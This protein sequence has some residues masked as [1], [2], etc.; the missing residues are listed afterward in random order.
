MLK[1]KD[2]TL[3][4]GGSQILYDVSLTAAAGE[5]TCIMGTNGVGKT[6]LLKA[7]S[8]THQ[9]TSGEIEFD[10]EAIGKLPAH[11]L[12]QKGIGYVPQGRMIFPLL[13]VKENMET[14]YAC[15]P[16]SEHYVPDEIY[17]L[18]PILKEFLNRRGGD[19]SGGQQQQLA[20][21]RAMLT[22]PKL[23]LLDEPT[24]GIQPNIIQQIGRVIRYL[25]DKGDIA[26]ILVEQYFDFA[27]EN[28]DRF[29]V[30][31][32]GA[33]MKSGSHDDLSRAELLEATSV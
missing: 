23:L 6:S 11:A 2:L 8:G 17:E 18:F 26:I 13:T 28:A 9:R 4:Y 27:Y 22:K 10:G 14:A 21:A 15:L 19:L 33:V 3:H 30:L 32:R 16:R 24:E 20:I 31:R 29:V 1:V 12:A 7:L 25:R 5:V